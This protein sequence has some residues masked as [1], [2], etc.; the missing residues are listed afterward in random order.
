M[1]HSIRPRRRTKKQEAP[2]PLTEPQKRIRE[3]LNGIEA[4]LQTLALE[5]LQAAGAHGLTLEEWARVIRHR[6]LNIPFRYVTQAMARLRG[7]WTGL[8]VPGRGYVYTIV[9]KKPKQRS[10]TRRR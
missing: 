2:K 6:D 10:L 4:T 9:N 8:H 1:P 7:K 5:Q 3:A